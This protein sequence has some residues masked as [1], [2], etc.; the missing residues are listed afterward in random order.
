[1]RSC[2]ALHNTHLHSGL[3]RGTAE[4]LGLLD[5]LA[6]Y[7]DPMHRAL[8]ADIAEAASRLCYAEA[9][10]GG[11]TSVMD[12]W[13]HLDRAAGVAEHPGASRDARALRVR[14]PVAGLLR[15]P[16]DQP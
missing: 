1:M 8:T 6:T 2:P 5:W 16:G 9:L 7:V 3:L 10:L 11:T 14:R 12:M 15:D 4:D 13:R